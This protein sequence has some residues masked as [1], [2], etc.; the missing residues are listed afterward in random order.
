MNVAFSVVFS[1]VFLKK[2]T[3]CTKLDIAGQDDT[4]FHFTVDY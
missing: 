4:F 3:L 1:V 2:N